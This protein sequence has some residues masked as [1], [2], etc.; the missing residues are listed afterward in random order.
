MY[1]FIYFGCSRGDSLQIW[2]VAANVLNKQLPTRD[3]PPAWG[4]GRGLTTLH[5][6][7][8]PFYKML[9]RASELAGSCEPNNELSGSIKGG[10]FLDYLSD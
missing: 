7:V 5:C 2:S 1:I 6:K 10:E 8:P 9:L 4:L 3:D